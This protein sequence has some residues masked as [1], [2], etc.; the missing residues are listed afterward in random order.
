MIEITLANGKSID[1]CL[2]KV[3]VFCRDDAS[4]QSYDLLDIAQDNSLNDLD[5]LAANNIRAQ[6]DGRAFL[7]LKRNRAKIEAALKSLP[8]DVALDDPWLDEQSMWKAIENAYLACWDEHV[9]Q[10]RITKV[11]HKK[12][13]QLIPLIDSVVVIGRYYEGYPGPKVGVPGMMGVSQR[14][15]QDMMRNAGPLRELQKALEEREIN[16]TRVRVFD[17]LLWM[18]YPVRGR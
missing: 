2:E 11:L 7:S 18:G 14:I 17:I 5:I 10:A 8:V 9:R 4:Y 15:R 12:R 13:P 16:L 6:M 3:L 1:D